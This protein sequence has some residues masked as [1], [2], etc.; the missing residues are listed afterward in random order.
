[1][2]LTRSILA[3]FLSFSLVSIS[4]LS[5]TTR[6]VFAQESRAALERGYRTGYSDG[7]MAGYRDVIDNNS[8]N[9]QKHDGY[10][11]ADR[12]Y[13]KDYGSL[14]NYR[15]GYRQG[16]EIGYSAGF[17]KRS[18]DA[19]IPG[20]LNKRV[21]PVENTS[22]ETASPETEVKENIPEMTTENTSAAKVEETP[23]KDSEQKISENV[24][25]ENS[26]NVAE[27]VQAPVITASLER[28][29]SSSSGGDII[30]IPIETELIVELVDEINTEQNR[31]GDK[32]KARVFS[33]SEIGGAIIEGR[34]AKI[35]KP[36]RLKRRAEMS[37]SFDR[38]ILAENRWSNF[39]AL[40][41]EVLPVKGDNVKRV[42]TEG[43]VEGK[44]TAKGDTVKVGGATGTGLVIGAIAGGPVGAAVGAGVGAAFGVGSVVVERGKHIRLNKNQQ[45]RIKTS[46]ETQIR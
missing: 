22:A 36:G 46:Y 33:P 43:T 21:L 31:E 26:E 10:T 4:I 42:D 23:T 44:S 9:Y 1:M 12:A 15:D 41:T 5:I 6:Q 28:S 19:A 14:E 3:L 8:R 20:D 16:F 30:V 13:N 45:L 18:F 37:L 27:T 34:I 24:A 40:L 32:F 2:K 11:K 35:Q 39:N 29:G 17:E 7:Y 38:I 25:V